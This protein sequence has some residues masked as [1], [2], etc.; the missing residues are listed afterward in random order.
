MHSHQQTSIDTLLSNNHLGNDVV[1]FDS[2]DKLL[3]LGATLPSPYMQEAACTSKSE[4][5]SHLS[6]CSHDLYI[7]L[8][9]TPEIISAVDENGMTLL[10][11]A[12]RIGF[13]MGSNS[14]SLI[15]Y[16]LFTAPGCDFNIKD[17]NGNTP[18]HI[19]AECCSDRVTQTYIFANYVRSAV[20]TDFDFSILNKQGQAVIHI[21]ART[22]YIDYVFGGLRINIHH[23]LNNVKN[24]DVDILSSSG[25]TAFYY[26]V[27]W[28]HL[29]DAKALLDAGA[30]PLLCGLPDR[31]PLQQINAHID[32]F[33]AELNSEPNENKREMYQNMIDNLTEL[34]QRV[35]VYAV[36]NN[37]T[38]GCRP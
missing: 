10:H 4:H 12:A 6:Q 17:H 37:N 22:S 36:E 35:L 34:K 14:A 23:L 32:D 20:K 11:H 21:A 8:R 5:L 28:L 15:H 30:N 1:N 27:N 38:R 33:T 31:E 25:S 26:A 3:E 19:A 2:A 7:A 9:K 13:M 24:I 29:K 18:L 16:L